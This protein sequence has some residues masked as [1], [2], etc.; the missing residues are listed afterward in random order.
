MGGVDGQEQQGARK[1][2]LKLCRGCGGKS[3][4]FDSGSSCFLI[5]SEINFW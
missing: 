1:G 3:T 4:I 2:T 5:E